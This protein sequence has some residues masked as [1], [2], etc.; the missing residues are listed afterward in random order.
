M[1][2]KATTR[3][4]SPQGCSAP[5]MTH[6]RPEERAQLEQLAV[7]EERSMSAMARLLIVQGL[8]KRARSSAH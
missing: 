7:R 1:T 2:T 6:L 3:S 5:V 4:P 8:Q